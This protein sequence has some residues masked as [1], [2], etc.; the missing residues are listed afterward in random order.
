M[1]AVAAAVSA[2][3]GG[4][5]S[6]GLGKALNSGNQSNANKSTDQAIDSTGLMAQ[7]GQ[8]QW[9]RYQS[10]YTPLETGM[11]S[12]AQGYDSPD[13]Y[14]RAAGD[15]QAVVG[16][17]FGKARERLMRTPGLDPSTPAY[18]AAMAGLDNAQ[19]AV[20]A[21]QQNMARQRVRDTAWARK[22]DAMGLGKGLPALAS[23]TLGG[24]TRNSMG[25]ADMAT[26]SG[27]ANSSMIG[28]VVNRAINPTTVKGGLDWL[29]KSS[30]ADVPITA[31]GG[32]GSGNDYGNQDLGLNF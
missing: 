13:N 8:E 31:N 1:S 30:G 28:N 27:I 21:T 16:S 3:V 29:S 25:L 17:Q 26:T 32:W 5:V 11:L 14:A 9:Q 7:I 24:A 23:A 2:G 6:Y 19:A 20:D 10:M 18:T 22:T 15:A 12:D 4:L